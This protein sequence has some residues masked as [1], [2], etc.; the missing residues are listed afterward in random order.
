MMSFW[1]GFWIGGIV[2]AIVMAM[3]A[4]GRN[5]DLDEENA[6][7]RDQ[8]DSVVADFNA[9]LEARCPRCGETF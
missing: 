7:L 2:G 1:I 3:L 5:A 6:T 8:R 9:A 4:A